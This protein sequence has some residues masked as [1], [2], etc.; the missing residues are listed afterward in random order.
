MVQTVFKSDS[1]KN[2]IEN[3]YLSGSEEQYLKVIQ[4]KIKQKIFIYQALRN[5]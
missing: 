3:F 2:K 5:I 1:D 4:I